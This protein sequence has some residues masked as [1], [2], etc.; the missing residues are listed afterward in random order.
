MAKSLPPL[1]SSRG[2]GKCFSATEYRG[3]VCVV[4]TPL[5]FPPSQVREGLHY[6]PYFPGGSIAMPKMIVDG[7]VEYDDGTPSSAS[8]QAKDVTTFLTWSCNP[9]Q[10]GGRGR[11][12]RREGAEEE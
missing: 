10:V 7:G 2:N 1:S 4:L 3:P 5:S 6:N 9:F 8:Q 12:G 11:A